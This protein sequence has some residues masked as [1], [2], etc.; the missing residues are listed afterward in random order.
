MASTTL[1]SSDWAGPIVLGGDLAA[2]R[3]AELKARAGRELQVHGSPTLVR[4]P[5]AAGLLDELRL[6]TF[7]TVVGAGARLFAGDVSTCL[8]L[9]GHQATRTGAVIASYRPDGPFRAGTVG[10]D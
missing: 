9:D 3:V 5:L 10:Q 2:T 8:R 6:L 4:W 7:P 1:A